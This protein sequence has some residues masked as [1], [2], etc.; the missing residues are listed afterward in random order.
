LITKLFFVIFVAK[1]VIV[2]SDDFD[3]TKIEVTSD[4]EIDISEEV[5][6]AEKLVPGVDHSKLDN[7][8][9]Y[10]S[11]FFLKVNGSLDAIVHETITIIDK[12]FTKAP[13]HL[14]QVKFDKSVLSILPDPMMRGILAD[15]N[16]RCFRKALTVIAQEHKAHYDNVVSKRAGRKREYKEL[17]LSQFY[18][19]HSRVQDVYENNE[20]SFKK[21]DGSETK[22]KRYESCVGHTERLYED[23]VIR[24]NVLVDK[25]EDLGILLNKNFV[26]WK[27]T[28]KYTSKNAKNR[29]LIDRS[30]ATEH[31]YYKDLVESHYKNYFKEVIHDP[32]EN[33][34]DTSISQKVSTTVGS[35]ANIFQH[36]MNLSFVKEAMQ[37]SYFPHVMGTVVLMMFIGFPFAVV[38]SLFKES[39][40]L[41]YF[42]M[43]FWVKCWMISLAI[44]Q[45][46]EVVIDVYFG[47]LS[48]EGGQLT[49]LLENCL[50]LCPMLSYLFINIST[51]AKTGGGGMGREMGKSAEGT[52]KNISQTGSD[53]SKISGGTVPGGVGKVAGGVVST[54]ATIAKGL[55]GF[56]GGGQKPP[57][58]SGGLKI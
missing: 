50:V 57:D 34:P 14:A 32:E 7:N 12:G 23:L 6:Y 26:D 5:K 52:A 53:M 4:P 17:S 51:F 20:I 55:T 58:K 24:H 35:M 18:P 25:G 29:K 19:S 36:Y 28:K 11:S 39:I 40:L 47:E 3:Y 37:L 21:L 27:G 15:Y 38:F 42:K 33:A 54:G 8:G 16:S 10:P 2:P 13:A 49:L 9:I 46:L 44:L 30:N 45:K 22:I 1:V 31:E 41:E 56:M 43:L 48:V